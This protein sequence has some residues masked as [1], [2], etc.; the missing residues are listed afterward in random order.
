MAKK[1]VELTLKWLEGG[2]ILT[3]MQFPK[4]NFLQRE[5]EKEREGQTERQRDSDRDHYFH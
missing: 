2:S 3:P 5:R 4:M 1:E